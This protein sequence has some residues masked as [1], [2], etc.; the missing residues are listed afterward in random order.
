MIEKVV[1]V[2]ERMPPWE[3]DCCCKPFCGCFDSDQ[4]GFDIVDDVDGSQH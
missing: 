4:V 1:V 2:E 3:S